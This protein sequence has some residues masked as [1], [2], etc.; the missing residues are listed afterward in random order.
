[1]EPCCSCSYLEGEGYFGHRILLAAVWQVF[2][3]DQLKWA[4]GGQGTEQPEDKFTN[5]RSGKNWALDLNIKIKIN[6]AR[7]W[8]DSKGL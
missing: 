4:D 1:M 8:R 6:F 7:L 5:V 3:Q 2:F